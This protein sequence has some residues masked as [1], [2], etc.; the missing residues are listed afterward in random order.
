ML[1][2]FSSIVDQCD[3]GTNVPT[4]DTLVTPNLRR[5]SDVGQS[6]PITHSHGIGCTGI[7]NAVTTPARTCDKRNASHSHSTRSLLSPRYIDHHRIWRA[8]TADLS[9]A[10]LGAVSQ[11]ELF[12]RALQPAITLSIARDSMEGVTLAVAAVRE[13]E[14]QCAEQIRFSVDSSQQDWVQF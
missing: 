4:C 3:T 2:R 8:N 13:P 10:H 5:F 12:S 6:W 14:S 11:R 7:R 1:Q 9:P